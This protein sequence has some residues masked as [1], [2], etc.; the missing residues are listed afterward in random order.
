[1]TGA[2]PEEVL[3][4][5]V[6][7]IK[8]IDSKTYIEFSKAYSKGILLPYTKNKRIRNFPC[9]EQLQIVLEKQRSAANNQRCLLFPNIRNNGYIDH[10]H[11][12]ARSWKVVLHSLVNDGQIR[13]Y[14]KP[15]A[16]RHSF[17]SRLI[18]QN[19]DIKTVATLAGN[20]PNVII[21]NYLG[22]KDNVNLP[23]L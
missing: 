20:S 14:L 13:K 7:D 17:I 12:A 8:S 2:R 18:H 22:A 11:F 19:W 5:T 16:L 3:A 1:M 15:Y 9:N 6:D 21:Q 4:L 10:C 23:P